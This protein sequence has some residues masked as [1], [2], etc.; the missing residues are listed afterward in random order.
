MQIKGRATIKQCFCGRIKKH[1]EFIGI[2]KEISHNIS[3]LVA[4]GTAEIERVKCPECEKG[5]RNG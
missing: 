3:L 1:G 5:G 2:D 4:K